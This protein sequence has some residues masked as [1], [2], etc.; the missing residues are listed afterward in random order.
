M[1]SLSEDQCV[2][3]R[4]P[5][6]SLVATVLSL[7]SFTALNTK[8]FPKYYPCHILLWMCF[9][10]A[11]SVLMFLSLGSFWSLSAFCSFLQQ[12]PLLEQDFG[13]I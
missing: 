9:A 8:I 6:K 10:F 7:A 11:H 13:V 4:T 2:A 1:D 5:R 3:K 12:S